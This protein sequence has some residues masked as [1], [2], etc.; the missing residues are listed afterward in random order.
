M[1]T[2]DLRARMALMKFPVIRIF[3]ASIFKNFCSVLT[4]LV[5]VF[6]QVCVI[7]LYAQ[8]G[9]A[10]P[11]QPAQQ[12]LSPD[13]AAQPSASGQ[14]ISP[15]EAQ[16]RQEAAANA[17]AQAYQEQVAGSTQDFMSDSSSLSAPEVEAQLQ[18]QVGGLAEQKLEQLKSIDT[19][20]GIGK[21]IQSQVGDVL[22]VDGADH[23]IVMDASETDYY[24]TAVNATDPDKP[25]NLSFLNTTTNNTATRENP[26]AH[27]TVTQQVKN[28]QIA[29]DASLPPATDPIRVYPGSKDIVKV[30]VGAQIIVEL[31]SGGKEWMSTEVHW[32]SEPEVRMVQAVQTASDG[33]K[34]IEDKIADG[35]TPMTAEDYDAVRKLITDLQTSLAT[36]FGNMNR[37]AGTVSE[38]D[39]MLFKAFYSNPPAYFNNPQYDGLADRARALLM[40]GYLKWERDRQA[41][42]NQFNTDLRLMHQNLFDA[43]AADLTPQLS[44]IQNRFAGRTELTMEEYEELTAFISTINARYQTAEDDYR[45]QAAVLSQNLQAALDAIVLSPGAQQAY[46]D[47]YSIARTRESY[48]TRMA[49]YINE[50]GAPIYG[51]K[52]F[53]GI[54]IEKAMT[55]SPQFGDARV[56]TN[57]AMVGDIESLI[58]GKNVTTVIGGNKVAVNPSKLMGMLNGELKNFRS[59]SNVP[60]ITREDIASLG[61]PL[62]YDAQTGRKLVFHLIERYGDAVIRDGAVDLI[63][64]SMKLEGEERV[65]VVTKTPIYDAVGNLSHYE[66]ATLDSAG[67]IAQKDY[68]SPD[69]KIYMTQTYTWGKDALGNDLVEG[70]T[71]RT[72]SY[73]DGVRQEPPGVTTMTAGPDGKFQTADD[74]LTYTQ[75]VSDGRTTEL[76]YTG[77]RDASGYSLLISKQIV[78]DAKTGKVVMATDYTKPLPPVNEFIKGLGSMNAE[79][80]AGVLNQGLNSPSRNILSPLTDLQIGYGNNLE[81]IFN[82]ILSTRSDGAEILKTLSLLRTDVWPPET[83]SNISAQ[84]GDQLEFL[85]WNDPKSFSAFGPYGKQWLMDEQKASFGPQTYSSTIVYY[86][87]APKDIKGTSTPIDL[88]FS[89]DITRTYTDGTSSKD[90]ALHQFQIIIDDQIPLSD[91]PIVITPQTGSPVHIAPGAKLVIQL[92]T[93][94]TYDYD[95]RSELRMLVKLSPGGVIPPQGKSVTVSSSA[96]TWASPKQI[97]TPEPALVS[98]TVAPVSAGFVYPSGGQFP[99]KFES[100]AARDQYM[101]DLAG[102]IKKIYGS[103]GPT[104]S[105]FDQAV[106][107]KFMGNLNEMVKRG[108]VT[109]AEADQIVVAQGF[110]KQ[111]STPP[112]APAP[113]AAPEPGARPAVINSIPMSYQPALLN[114]RISELLSLP[115]GSSVNITGTFMTSTM[116]NDPKTGE[117]IYGNTYEVTKSDGSKMYVDSVEK[118]LNGGVTSITVSL[119]TTMTSDSFRTA[120]PQESVTREPE[121]AVVNPNQIA[122]PAEPPVAVPT[123]EPA[124][125]V[126]PDQVAQAKRALF[127]TR[128]ADKAE[129]SLAEFQEVLDFLDTLDTDSS[130]AQKDVSEALSNLLARKVVVMDIAGTEVKVYPTGLISILTEAQKNLP[131]GEDWPAG[132]TD[133]DLAASGADDQFLESDLRLVVYMVSHY[134]QAFLKDGAID[135]AAFGQ[136]VRGENPEQTSVVVPPTGELPTPTPTTTP[137]AV[138]VEPAPITTTI[139]QTV[140]TTTTVPPATTTTAIDEKYSAQLKSFQTQFANQSEISL[141]DYNNIENIISSIRA[142]YKAENKSYTDAAGI[143]KEVE[144]LLSSKNVALVL[145]DGSKLHV[146]PSDVVEV[147]NRTRRDIGIEFGT[148]GQQLSEVPGVTAE[149]QKN[150]GPGEADRNLPTDRQERRLALNLIQRLGKSV[151]NDAGYVDRFALRKELLGGKP[152]ESVD[153]K[154]DAGGN[155]KVMVTPNFRGKEISISLG[156]EPPPLITMDAGNKNIQ[157]GASIFDITNRD[158]VVKALQAITDNIN[159]MPLDR[160]SAQGPWRDVIGKVQEFVRVN[161]PATEKA[162]EVVSAFRSAMSAGSSSSIPAD[163]PSSFWMGNKSGEEQKL[164]SS[165]SSR[166]ARLSLFE[167]WQRQMKTKN[168]AQQ[169]ISGFDE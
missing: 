86:F 12:Q 147:I 37:A 54:M 124:V 80:V 135:E 87:S 47:A 76:F 20:T 52:D 136:W 49:E 161:S 36:E 34:A 1:K 97:A 157:I 92:S 83:L 6:T 166:P 62:V 137:T 106:T 149:D 26:Y 40:S 93:K 123:P 134:G 66:T 82:A 69:G 7:P 120:P 127:E 60:G 50:I 99:V 168:R 116:T 35:T 8:D 143:E 32:A 94:T 125:V 16:R 64:F 169:H 105:A 71:V 165:A 138:G 68:S 107:D 70:Q 10:P 91:K 144:A 28:L 59:L 100:A 118:R 56:M 163:R 78:R 162:Q 155:I 109:Q 4:V 85:G 77:E 130:A 53:G 150:I 2:N 101:S 110:V 30:P 122:P 15:E 140:A 42:I 38:E 17:P 81:M 22:R 95:V 103:Q 73:T 115:A 44:D 146:S 98:T 45:S 31:M 142:D 153:I 113:V 25:L 133:A 117:G 89:E 29:V 61:T 19:T 23:P 154:D 108:L 57:W 24:L 39:V 104:G 11:P 88:T 128:F 21:V 159:A 152:F 65:A 79:D 131:A 121:P 46:N 158:D 145:E 3:F 119:N 156:Q 51:I 5:F 126:N 84:T 129:V 33:L 18:T 72:F 96:F 27:P 43:A 139:N 14:V 167:L 102:Y 141:E 48:Q 90:S 74:V 148:E 41:P 67:R 164:S 112:A 63:A 58:A 160:S 151:A 75:F 55:R 9:G 114:Q 132:I 13:Q 111:V